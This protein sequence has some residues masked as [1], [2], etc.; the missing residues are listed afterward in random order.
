MNLEKDVY[1]PLKL[2]LDRYNSMLV[3]HPSYEPGGSA[4]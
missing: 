1:G 4:E 2:W 3:S